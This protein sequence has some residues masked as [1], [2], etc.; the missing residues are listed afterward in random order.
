MIPRWPLPMLI[1]I[2]IFCFFVYLCVFMIDVFMGLVY[3]TR[4]LQSYSKNKKMCQVFPINSKGKKSWKRMCIEWKRWRKCPVWRMIRESTRMKG[5]TNAAKK[6]LM[7]VIEEGIQWVWV[8]EGAAD[9]AVEKSAI[10]LPKLYIPCV[11][12]C[13]RVLC[14][15]AG[16]FG[17]DRILKGSMVESAPTNTILCQHSSPAHHPTPGASCATHL[18][19]PQHC[20]V[21]PHLACI[22]LLCLPLRF[23]LLQADSFNLRPRPTCCSVP[24]VI[25]GWLDICCRC[26]KLE[27]A[28][29]SP[30]KKICLTPLHCCVRER[31]WTP[32]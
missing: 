7:V 5:Y 17:W 23:I 4:V 30:K 25:L 10:N 21:S 24:A 2:L 12:G 13:V 31:C 1:Q 29:Q 11:C 14:F 26:T 20:Q 8:R 27:T 15:S 16:M 22:S 3:L 32:W 28:V 9:I 18:A 19:V 6:R